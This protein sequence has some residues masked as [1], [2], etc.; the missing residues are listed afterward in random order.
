CWH[1]AGREIV[2]I[3][4]G[5]LILR[6]EVFGIGRSREFDRNRVVDLR[7][8]APVFNPWA[9]NA[10]LAFWGWA[11]RAIAFDYGARTYF[12]GVGLQEAEARMLVAALFNHLPRREVSTS[13]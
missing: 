3:T 12:F 10:T 6:K 13:G 1:L 4:S 7:I 11:S 5:E 2:R 9:W 8:G